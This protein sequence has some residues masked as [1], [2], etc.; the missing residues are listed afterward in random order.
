MIT[1]PADPPLKVFG[2]GLSRTGTT[3]LHAASVLM[4]LSAWHYPSQAAFRWFL[5]DFSAAT[6]QP[7]AAITDLPTPLFFEEL[8][9]THPRARFILT[10]RD[11]E[12]WLD[13]FEAFL[14]RTRPSSPQTLRRDIIRI[15]CYGTMAFHRE[16]MAGVYLRH[17]D[18]VQTYFRHRASDLLVLDVK[19]EP[20]PWQK[21]GDFLSLP[22]PDLP[23]PHL[24]APGIGPLR[25]VLPQELG[26]KRDAMIRLAFGDPRAPMPAE[27]DTA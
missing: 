16:R 19:K 17:I 13:S 5:G 24:R 2:I 7:F 21:L 14:G 12:S 8:D 4:G 3:S 22:L 25:C 11:V 20:R 1:H 23:F 15:A 10:V 26:Q 27:E 18:R 9:K 6:T